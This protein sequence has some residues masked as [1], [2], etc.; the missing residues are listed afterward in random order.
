ML[1]VRTVQCVLNYFFFFFFDVIFGSGASK[2]QVFPPTQLTVQLSNVSLGRGVPFFAAVFCVL[3]ERDKDAILLLERGLRCFQER[4]ISVITVRHCIAT[5]R[6][7]CL[8]FF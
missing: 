2:I 3:K 6:L 4:R 5:S 1:L 8:A 7:I